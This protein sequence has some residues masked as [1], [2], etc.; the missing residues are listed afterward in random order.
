MLHDRREEKKEA[1]KMIYTIILIYSKF[2][3]NFI[4]TQTLLEEVFMNNKVKHVRLLVAFTLAVL[5]CAA[6]LGGCGGT[7]DSSD[8]TIYGS[9]S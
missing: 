4:S 3:Y 5:A 1:V 7:S 8:H 2:V 9:T 6:L